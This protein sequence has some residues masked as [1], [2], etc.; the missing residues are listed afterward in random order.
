VDA[1]SFKNSI[2]GWI[3]GPASHTIKN[4]SDNKFKSLVLESLSSIFSISISDIEKRLKNLK[5][6]N[7][8]K[9]PYILGG[10]SY[11]TLK[12]EEARDILK[13]PFKNSIYFAGEYLAENSSSTVDAA[14]KSAKESCRGI[15]KNN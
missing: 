12:T 5:V 6:M 2:A 11:P 15:L 8:I 4:Y 10:Y 14:L 9:E 7:W 13:T 3:A 1:I